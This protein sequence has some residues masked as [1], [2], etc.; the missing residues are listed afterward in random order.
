MKFWVSPEF[1]KA[2]ETGYAVEKITK[3]WHLDGRSDSIFIDYMHTFCLTFLGLFRLMV[4]GLH[5]ALS[6]SVDQL[7]RFST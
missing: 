7:K 5:L 1:N 2:L 6:K 3:V 4:N